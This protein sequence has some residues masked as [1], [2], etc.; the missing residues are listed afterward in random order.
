MMIHIAFFLAEEQVPVYSTDVLRAAASEADKVISDPE[1]KFSW[2][3]GT[4]PGLN[5]SPQTCERI[6]AVLSAAEK[7]KLVGD[8]H[9]YI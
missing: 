3:I 8:S 6:G 4:A 1:L 5:P 2:A 9:S 7:L